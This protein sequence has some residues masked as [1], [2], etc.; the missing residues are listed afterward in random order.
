MALVTI[1]ENG[2]YK[3]LLNIASFRS[4]Y[5]LNGGVMHLGCVCF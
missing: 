2:I 4:H 3:G 1:Y 5:K